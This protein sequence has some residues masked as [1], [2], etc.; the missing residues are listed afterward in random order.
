MRANNLVTFELVRTNKRAGVETS[1]KMASKLVS[2]SAYEKK[3]FAG[4]AILLRDRCEVCGEAGP[5]QLEGDS[6]GQP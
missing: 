2:F 1:P 4:A 3:I 6:L 5:P